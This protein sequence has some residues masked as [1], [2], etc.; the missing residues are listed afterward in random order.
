VRR[1]LNLPRDRIKERNWRIRKQDANA[2]YKDDAGVL[3]FLSSDTAG[4]YK[5]IDS[6]ITDEVGLGL[7]KRSKESALHR[8]QVYRLEFWNESISNRA[9]RGIVKHYFSFVYEQLRNNTKRF[10]GIFSEALPVFQKYCSSDAG[11]TFS[12]G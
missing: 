6:H 2:A 4:K 7:G 3:K 9:P 1:L 12:N 10:R 11:R 5:T 8:R